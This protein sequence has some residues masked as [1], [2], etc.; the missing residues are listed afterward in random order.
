MCY[1]CVDCYRELCLVHVVTS[2]SSFSSPASHPLPRP[3]GECLLPLCPDTVDAAAGIHY[4]P[5]CLFFSAASPHHPPSAS[6][7]KL[8]LGARPQTPSMAPPKANLVLFLSFVT[9]LGWPVPLLDLVHDPGADS[10]RLA[11]AC[12]GSCWWSATLWPGCCSHLFLLLLHHF[13]PSRECV[14]VP[15]IVCVCECVCGRW[16]VWW[17]VYS[18]WKLAISLA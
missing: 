9:L 14:C 12:A 8:P 2:S 6:H 11:G 18:G 5:S 3:N 17:W 10:A 15:L 4:L 7:Q 1:T 13:P 16:E